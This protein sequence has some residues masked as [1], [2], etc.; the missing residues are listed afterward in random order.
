MDTYIYG[1][2]TI[3]YVL[4]AI[5]GLQ[6]LNK[7][8]WK[9]LSNVLLLVTLGLVWDNGLLT[10]GNWIRQGEWLETLS[11]SRFWLHAFLTPLLVLFA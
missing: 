6:L 3:A 11:R 8:G 10:A 2:F 5:Y 9:S 7:Y 4:L 1:L